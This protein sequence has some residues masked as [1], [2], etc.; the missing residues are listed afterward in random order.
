VGYNHPIGLYLA[1]GLM[2]ES[3]THA[4]VASP[5]VGVC[6]LLSFAHSSCFL[7]LV[8]L[9]VFRIA[10]IVLWSADY[11]KDSVKA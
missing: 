9:F 2:G 4:F 6:P 3:V 11:I 10:A 1:A 7:F 5:F 8:S